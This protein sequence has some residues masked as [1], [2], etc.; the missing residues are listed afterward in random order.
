MQENILLQIGT[1]TT[2]RR[3]A[4]TFHLQ[5]KILKWVCRSEDLGV[6]RS[7]KDLN[8]NFMLPE[9]LKTF[10]RSGSGVQSYGKHANII[11]KRSFMGSKDFF[12]C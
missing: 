1:K 12:C 3:M 10:S 7:K 11:L 8:P 9:G 6:T 5:D 2:Y 4:I